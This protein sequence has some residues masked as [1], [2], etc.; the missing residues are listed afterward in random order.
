MK[1]AIVNIAKINMN[2][3]AIDAMNGARMNRVII[4]GDDNTSPGI[5]GDGF[6][7]QVK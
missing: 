2:G 5:E 6:G 3:K 1:N 4:K 7:S